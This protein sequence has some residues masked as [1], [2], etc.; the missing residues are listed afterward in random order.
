MPA[1]FVSQLVSLEG[2]PD[3][4]LPPVGEAAPLPDC[5][6]LKLLGPPPAAP[7][8]GTAC[9]TGLK[10]MGDAGVSCEGFA[11]AASDA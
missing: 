7:L 8:S 11:S 3:L 4:G 6:G 9:S 1:R 2:L 10:L 5:T